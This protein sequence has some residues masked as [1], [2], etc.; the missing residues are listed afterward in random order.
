M[1]E[2]GNPQR[3]EQMRRA[4]PLPPPREHSLRLLKK[5]AWAQCKKGYLPLVAIMLLGYVPS[6]LWNIGFAGWVPTYLSV[7][8]RAAIALLFY[9][10]TLGGVWYTWFL[11]LDNKQPIKRIFQFFTTAEGRRMALR[12]GLVY[13]GIFTFCLPLLMQLSAWLMKSYTPLVQGYSALPIFII[14]FS[15]IFRLRLLPYVFLVTPS[16]SI[17]QA[18]LESFARTRGTIGE[19]LSLALSFMG[20]ITL[21]MLA[22]G[23]LGAAI[24]WTGL[25]SMDIIQLA[26]L[27]LPYTVSLFPGPY[28]TLAFAG[29]AN[30]YLQVPY[31]AL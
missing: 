19:Q 4:Q 12:C 2:Y 29:L 21:S 16:V 7:P 22:T 30:E 27:A 23:L 10:V 9:P 28:F 6:F 13:I 5:R 17:R 3:L 25:F 8:G 31:R 24:K 15:L 18:V 20:W 14:G 1:S 11:F 26:T